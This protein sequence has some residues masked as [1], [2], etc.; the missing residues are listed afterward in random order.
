M[1][2]V[3]FLVW[4]IA[5]IMFVTGLFMLLFPASVAR[6]ES[7]LNAPWGDNEILNIRLGVSGE[8]RAEKILNKNILE[9]NIV[10]DAWTKKFPRLTGVILC[11]GALILIGFYS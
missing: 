10:W 11:I 2:I 6:V 8:K 9:Q 5:L 1:N 4:T 7:K 3:D